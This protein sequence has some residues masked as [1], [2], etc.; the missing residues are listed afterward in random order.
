MFRFANNEIFW[1]F[2]L[3][4]IAIGLYII[5]GILKRTALKRFG[6]TE[7]ITQLM[8]DTS[9]V[10]PFF[11]FIL[12]LLALAAVILAAARPQLGTRLEEMKREGVEIIIALDVSNSM[13]AE[14]ISPNRLERAKMAIQRLTDRLVND[15]IGLIVFAGKSF[16]QVPLTTDYAIT[17]M[18]TATVSTETVQVQ[19]TA[20]G[21]A[22]DLAVNSFS[23]TDGV[24]KILIII[25]DGENHEDNPVESAK[26]ASAKGIIIHSIGIGDPRRT[27]VPVKGRGGTRN[28]LTDQE[29]NIVMTRLDETTLRQIASV[30]GGTYVRAT[31]AEFGLNNILNEIANM[32][33]TEFESLVYTGYEDKYQYFAGLA[34]ILLFLIGFISERKSY[35]FEKLNIFNN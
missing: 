11:K 23:N 10:K 14:D 13:L 7:I 16:V 8:P 29:G 26:Q 28:F 31:G 4:A 19:G 30:A 24:S 18:M 3:I 35:F 1:L 34:L 33:K 2:W 27:P 9:F 12:L 21:S 20:I 5:A 17:K 25:S 6:S 15:K 32:E 22:I